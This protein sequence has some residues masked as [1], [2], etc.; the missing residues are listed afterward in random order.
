MR[1]YG[2]TKP[3]SGGTFETG[4][5][6]TAILV[7]RV[8]KCYC[9]SCSKHPLYPVCLDTAQ[10]T[11][12]H[13]M[14]EA[15]THS[16]WQRLR[17][18]QLLNILKVTPV[19]PHSSLPQSAWVFAPTHLRPLSSEMPDTQQIWV[20]LALLL[21]SASCTAWRIIAAPRMSGK[22]PLLIFQPLN[23]SFVKNVSD[24]RRASPL[25]PAPQR[26]V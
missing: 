16:E 2:I 26:M 23:S 8:L 1:C 14:A 5:V 7:A 11:G 15:G 24:L 13:P 18:S 21:C 9:V 6:P 17:L 12:P 25:A 19:E 20:K 10:G 22:Q 3:G 4:S